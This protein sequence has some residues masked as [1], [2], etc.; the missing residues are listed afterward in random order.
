MPSV[1]EKA[2]GIYQTQMN[3]MKLVERLLTIKPSK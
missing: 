3:N 2:S 1:V